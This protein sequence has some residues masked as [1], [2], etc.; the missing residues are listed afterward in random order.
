MSTYPIKA[1]IIELVPDIMGRHVFEV[2]YNVCKFCN[3]PRVIRDRKR[4]VIAVDEKSGGSVSEVTETNYDQTKFPCSKNPRRSP[5][6]ADVLRAMHASE[7]C[8]DGYYSVGIDG[9]IY[10]VRYTYP[11]KEHCIITHDGI[12]S[13]NLEKDYDGQTEE[14]K[15]FIGSLLGV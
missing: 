15:T 4:D 13:W 8:R 5:S 3:E 12:G 7:N 14:T 1:K 2:G 6:L 11:D 10:R 9:G